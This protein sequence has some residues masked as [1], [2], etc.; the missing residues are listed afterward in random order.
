MKPMHV[1]QWRDAQNGEM[2]ERGTTSI[3]LLRIWIDRLIA[4][5]VTYR[6]T[7]E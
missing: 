2:V 1:L 6:Y 7:L 5:G 3:D 4:A